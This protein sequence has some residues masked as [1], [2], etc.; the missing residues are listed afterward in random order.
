MSVLHSPERKQYFLRKKITF[1]GHYLSAGGLEWNEEKMSAI[2]NL[3]LPTDVKMIQRFL[4]TVNFVSKHI[5]NMSELLKPINDLLSTKNE[6]I[7]GSLQQVALETKKRNLKS[8]TPLAFFNPNLSTMIS[9]SAS[10]YGLGGVLLQLQDDKKWLPVSFISRSLS[11]AE[12]TYLNIEPEALVTVWRCD[13]LKKYV[14]GKVIIVE[15]DHR[16]L[17]NIIRKKMSQHGFKGCKCGW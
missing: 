12:R 14:I 17:L 4:G 8:S 9:A 6:W 3:R 11:K 7:W 13:K 5:P 10:S 15:T 16:S 1:L 2:T